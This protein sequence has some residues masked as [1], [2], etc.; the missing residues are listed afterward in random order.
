[1][2]NL[3]QTER[4]HNFSV[5]TYINFLITVEE[6][7]VEIPIIDTPPNSIDAVLI[8]P[9]N[10][11][12]TAEGS[13]PPRYQW[14]KDGVQLLGETRPFLYIEEAKPEDRGNYTC[15]ATNRGGQS[16]SDPALIN[17]PGQL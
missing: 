14:S 8:A 11:T 17:I 1:M 3:D 7:P 9:I 16:K 15:V 4:S 2:F 5:T 6:R 10:L 13:P 12:C